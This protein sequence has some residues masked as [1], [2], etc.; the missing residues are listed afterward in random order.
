MIRRTF[1]PPKGVDVF[2]A[3]QRE[4]RQLRLSLVAALLIALTVAARLLGYW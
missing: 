4:R 1:E 2:E 3:S